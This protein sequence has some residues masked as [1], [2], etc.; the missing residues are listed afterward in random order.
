VDDLVASSGG[1]QS[2]KQV[3]FVQLGP[4]AGSM[5]WHETASTVG[6]TPTCHLSVQSFPETLSKVGAAAHA[7]PPRP[8]ALG[9]P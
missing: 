1:H 8:G 5:V 6:G 9:M 2:D 7:S 3:E 4:A